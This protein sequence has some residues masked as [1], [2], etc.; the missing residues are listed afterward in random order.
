M[1][2]TGTKYV[3]RIEMEFQHSVMNE[4]EVK[5]IGRLQESG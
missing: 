1:P 5:K 4:H 3:F 2:P